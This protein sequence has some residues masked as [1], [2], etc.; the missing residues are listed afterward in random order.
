MAVNVKPS[1]A[2]S[3]VILGLLRA[4]EVANEALIT[5][6]LPRR[7]G[8]YCDA[9]TDWHYR[10]LVA[11][12]IVGVAIAF[13]IMGVVPGLLAAAAGIV[14]FWIISALLATI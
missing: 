5:L 10:L 8:G 11:V 4:R 9:E 13:L 3:A 14:G 12:I 7:G 6:V 1:S 2:P